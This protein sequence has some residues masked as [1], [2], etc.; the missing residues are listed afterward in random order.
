MKDPTRQH[1]FVQ[2]WKAKASKQGRVRSQSINILKAFK[3]DE[4]KELI[5]IAV[6]NNSPH[7]RN[8]WMKF[9]G[10]FYLWGQTKRLS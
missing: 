6:K 8:H 2:C 4:G 10:L 9:H 5:S 1:N 3:V 7:W